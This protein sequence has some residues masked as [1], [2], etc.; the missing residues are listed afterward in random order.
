MFQSSVKQENKVMT[1][2]PWRIAVLAAA[3]SL[4]LAAC[5]GKD[6]A[7]AQQQGA[8]AKQQMPAPTVSDTDG[9]EPREIAVEL[10]DA[11]RQP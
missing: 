4:A 11:R 8:G 2:Q 9:R 1:I 5:G 3:I 7:S 6:G 10:A